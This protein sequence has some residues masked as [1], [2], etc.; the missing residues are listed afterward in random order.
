MKKLVMGGILMAIVAGS[1]VASKLTLYR[2]GAV[3]EFHPKSGFLGFLPRGSEAYCG[4]EKRSLL[5]S[6]DCPSQSRLCRL[7]EKIESYEGKAERADRSVE[8][9]RTLVNNTRSTTIDATQWIRTAEAVGQKMAALKR[10]AIRYKRLAA[11]AKDR[12]NKQAPS[13]DGRLLSRDCSADVTLKLPKGSIRFSPMVRLDILDEKEAKIEERLRLINRSGLD[14]VADEVT[15]T[16][17]PIHRYFHPILF[18]PWLVTDKPVVRVKSVARGTLMALDNQAVP[19]AEASAVEVKK[20]RHY[21][22]NALKLPSTGEPLD[23][24]VRTWKQPIRSQEIVF[25]WRSLEVFKMLTFDPK[26]PIE[27]NRW[28]VLQHGKLL[29]DRVTGGWVDGRYCLFYGVDED[30]VVQKTQAILKEKESFFGGRVKKPDGYTI[31]LI[32]QS[33]ATKN[34]TIVERIP[35]AVRSDVDVTLERVSSDRPMR[36]ELGEKGR[37]TIHV[38]LPPKTRGK[39][40]VRFRVAYDKKKPVVY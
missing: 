11:L 20:A 28:Q 23:L 34:V 5:I 6:P 9:L 10:T 2:D 18:A 32:N 14:I 4:V 29:S 36:Y 13:W 38:T 7:K 8:T 22:L 37:L 31:R 1:S 15:L 30:V 19:V 16:Y 3:Y 27:Q 26:Q 24:D 25:P 40:E 39:V 12:F 33:D 21:R 35:V 17:E